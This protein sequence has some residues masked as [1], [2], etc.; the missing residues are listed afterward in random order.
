MKLR[1]QVR[2]KLGQPLSYEC[3]RCGNCYVCETQDDLREVA[4]HRLLHLT[5]N[6]APSSN[7]TTQWI[8]DVDGPRPVL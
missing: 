8:S 1:S 3:S 5:A 4:N 7:P 2:Q 6:W